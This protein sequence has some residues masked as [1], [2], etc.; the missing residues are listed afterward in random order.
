MH[1]LHDYVA[2]QLADKI[3]SSR[4]VVWYDE[5][6]EFQPFV[7][8]VRGGSP[9]VS[10]P[11]PVAVAGTRASLAEFSGS[12]LELR[13]DA[14]APIVVYIPGITRDRRA[15]VLMELEESGP[16]WERSSSNSPGTSCSR[17]TPSASSTRCC[18]STARSPTRIL[19]ARLPAAPA[20]SRRRFYRA[21]STTPAATT[22]SSRRGS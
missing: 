7:D 18:L 11:V 6:G 19:R 20:R 8:E 1:L 2:R 9:T 17:S 14:P 13:G 4:V 22:V 12:M 16:S 5:R 21:S 15:S 10:E 3:E